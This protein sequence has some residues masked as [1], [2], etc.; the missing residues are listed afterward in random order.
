MLR[1]FV[2]RTM[3]EHIRLPATEFEKTIE[4]QVADVRRRW[5]ESDY[6]AEILCIG[7]AD[8]RLS[9]SSPSAGDGAS[10][11]PLYDPYLLPILPVLSWPAYLQGHQPAAL[12][13]LLGGVLISVRL[14]GLRSGLL[15]TLL[16]VLAVLFIALALCT[17][18]PAEDRCRH[19]RFCLCFGS[20]VC[21]HRQPGGRAAGQ[22]PPAFR[23][24]IRSAAV[25]VCRRS[26]SHAGVLSTRM[27][28][29]S[30]R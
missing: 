8:R 18:R 2:K 14:G 12:P 22:R 26:D 4:R 25:S 13:I 6:E 15:A 9:G 17:L 7:F 24:G 30:E 16:Y 29:Y 5:E 1:K 10:P 11:T 27:K 23:S 19:V 21:S 28:E 3:D 20:G